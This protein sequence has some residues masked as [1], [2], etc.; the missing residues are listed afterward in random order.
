MIGR[1]G[2]YDSLRAKLV[3][4]F[5]VVIALVLGLGLTGYSDLSNARRISNTVEPVSELHHVALELSESLASLDDNLEVF[6]IVRGSEQRAAVS[7]DLADLTEAQSKLRAS[8]GLEFW[9]TY[10]SA[11]ILASIDGLR[12]QVE[13]FVAAP[14]EE[15]SL[16][17]EAVALLF[18][19]VAETAADNAEFYHVSEEWVEDAVASQTGVLESLNTRF[20]VVGS[21]VLAIV[22]FMFLAVGRSMSRISSMTATATAIA[23]GDLGPRVKV[24]GGDEIAELAAAFNTM[25]EQLGELI[26]ELE[27][28]VA[29]RTADLSHANA[30]LTDEIH[31]RER[32]EMDMR[33]A[34]EFAETVLNSMSDSISIVDVRD[35]TIVGANSVFLAQYGLTAEE[36][37]G[38]SCHAVT[39]GRAQPCEPPNDVCPLLDSVA[40]GQTASAEHQHVTDS[41]MRY[42][43]VSASPIRNDAG[44]IIQV[45]H[46]SR[47]VTERRR[48]EAALETY[49][50][51]LQRSNGALQEFA[52]VAS[53]DLQEPLRKVQSF[54]SR[55][56]AKYGSQLDERGQDYLQRMQGAAARMQD[57][58]DGL[59]SYSRVTSTARPFEQVDLVEV[60]EGVLSDLEVRLDEVEGKVIIGELPIIEADGLQMRQLFQNLIGN[61]LKFT[62]PHEPPV[63]MVQA[64][65]LD[66]AGLPTATWSISVEDNGIGFDAKYA[67]RIFGVFQRLHGRGEYAGTGIGLAV[68][69]KIVERHGG[70]IEAAS[71]PGEG[72]TF[73]ITLPTTQSRGA[74]E[75]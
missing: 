36:L 19:S 41:G 25:T 29:E 24:R 30:A 74:N 7:R 22:G 68:C 37:R 3:A 46:V 40:S 1:R 64:R 9:D 52:Y 5:V 35:F 42:A 65:P 27:E 18:R 51:E 34:K 16:N 31:E 45:V 12:T 28:R 11:P 58:I 26:E 2:F 61:A 8:Q 67:D 23:G 62:R 60:V 47:D 44:D 71:S 13:A 33:H 43:E 53:H 55:L 17:N 75:R 50:S 73:V 49:A 14:A 59:L 10:D 6:V 21:A 20:I 69:K 54:G 66:A 56:Q 63:V 72:T 48:A 70:T 4:V 15:A 38:R 32:A 57:L 39:H